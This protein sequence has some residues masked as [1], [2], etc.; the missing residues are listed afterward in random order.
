[1]RRDSPIVRKRV[2]PKR[3]G[4]QNASKSLILAEHAG[5]R[6]LGMTAE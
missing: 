6:A 1:M 3:N 2:A 5:E 4:K